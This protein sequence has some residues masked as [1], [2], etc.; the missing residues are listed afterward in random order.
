MII[1]DQYNF[2]FIHVPKTAGNT[3]E[4]ALPR[5]RTTRGT[6]HYRLSELNKGGRYAFGFTRN[7]WDRMVS[8]YS[9]RCQKDNQNN[10]FNQERLREAGFEK[11][12]LTGLLGQDNPPWCDNPSIKLTNDSMFWLEGC[13]FIGRFE[14]LQE[15]YL[16]ICKT[17]NVPIKPL[18]R[19]NQSIHKPYQEYYTDEMVEYV[20][21]HH[22]PTIDR[23]GYT[24]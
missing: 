3:I 16:K 22:K 8:V 6:K 14:N 17:I 21:I 18:G 1:N 10:K 24:F 19:R 4:F 9:F 2:I 11:A 23:F 15:D 5:N 13:D 12:L 20:A 7:P